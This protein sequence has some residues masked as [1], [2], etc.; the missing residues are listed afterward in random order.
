VSFV[1]FGLSH[2]RVCVCVACGA[3]AELRSSHYDRLLARFE[4]YQRASRG[5]CMP[6]DGC[7]RRWTDFSWGRGGRKQRHAADVG[8]HTNAVPHHGVA[9]T[10]NAPSPLQ[11]QRPH[12]RHHRHHAL[13]APSVVPLPGGCLA[14]LHHLRGGEVQQWLPPGFSTMEHQISVDIP[15]T[16]AGYATTLNFP[17][18]AAKLWRILGTFSAHNPVIGYCQSMN[19]VASFLF[20]ALR[21]E[22]ATL[23]VGCCVLHTCGVGGRVWVERTV[24]QACTSVFLRACILPVVCVPCVRVCVCVCVCVWMLEAGW[25]R[26]A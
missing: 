2:V 9:H 3:V 22:R 1:C 8:K 7:A 24:R 13:S 25:P 23:E 5:R 6:Q 10:T 15:R 18:G 11:H 20:I 17:G 14:Q 21:D 12:L 19:T 16:L 26:C 4:L